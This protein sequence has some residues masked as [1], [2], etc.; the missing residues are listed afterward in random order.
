MGKHLDLRLKS[1]Y[2]EKFS[3]SS[4]TLKKEK[5]VVAS[6]LIEVESK[7]VISDITDAVVSGGGKEA[8]VD[9]SR[10]VASTST[11]SSTAGVREFATMA[12]G[13]K[14]SRSMANTEENQGMKILRDL[15]TAEKATCEATEAENMRARE[16][17]LSDRETMLNLAADLREVITHIKK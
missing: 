7:K 9:L 11:A 1:L 3:V 10:S 16:Q 8:L 2:L 6:K 5:C 14:R 13:K 17:A 4:Q 15:I 12:K